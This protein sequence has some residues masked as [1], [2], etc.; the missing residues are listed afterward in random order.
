MK[1]DSPHPTSARMAF[2]ARAAAATCGCGVW[3][4]R[5]PSPSN[6]ADWPSRG[7]LEPLR[8]L[9]AR[10]VP[11]VIPADIKDIVELEG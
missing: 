6:I 4:E 5:V 3:Y 7:H 11:F 8:R 10:E 1:G 2:S 9:G